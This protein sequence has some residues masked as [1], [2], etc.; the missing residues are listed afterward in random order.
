[1]HLASSKQIGICQSDCLNAIK[2]CFINRMQFERYCAIIF[3]F[4]PSLPLREFPC[5]QKFLLA[6]KF[7][8]KSYERRKVLRKTQAST[9]V[10]A[11]FTQT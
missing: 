3:S 2:Q 9:Q 4:F 1:M 11:D 6:R 8:A 7:C 5:E 10:C